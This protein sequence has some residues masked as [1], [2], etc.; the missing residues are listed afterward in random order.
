M[1][2]YV[3]EVVLYHLQDT[4]TL[5]DGAIKNQFLE[6]VVAILILHDLGHLLTYFIQEEL[7]HG[8]S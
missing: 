8:G 2:T 5:L 6:E 7:D 4:D 1:T 3:N